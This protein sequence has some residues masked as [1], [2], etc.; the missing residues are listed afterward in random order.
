MGESFDWKG[1]LQEAVAKDGRSRREIST[2]AGM[3]YNYLSQILSDEKMPKIENL[4]NV[5]RALGISP[6]YIL[7]GIEITPRVEELIRIFS[8]APE[9]LQLAMLALLR[10]K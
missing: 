5:C 9:H 7:S 8:D 10:G 1:R 2:A 6:V 4:E 3:S